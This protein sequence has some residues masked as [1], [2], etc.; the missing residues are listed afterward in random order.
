MNKFLFDDYQEAIEDFTKAIELKPDSAASAYLYRGLAKENLADS[1]GA[2]AD[3]AK[4]IEIEHLPKV[5]A[6]AYRYRGLVKEIHA[7]YQGALADYTRS[8]EL[9]PNVAKTYFLR[10]L[11]ANDFEDLGRGFELSAGDPDAYT[12]AVG[13]GPCFANALNSRGSAKD[14]IGNHQGAIADYTKA[15]ELVPGYAVPYR[16][17]GHSYL[18]LKQKDRA[19]ADFLRAIE[20]G[21]PV[22]QNILDMCK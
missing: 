22:P 12:K 21:L 3:L 17:R 13:L 5:I 14:Y 11:A 20:L 7:D 16:N 10:G 9:E 4:A 18:Y 6:Y 8:I 15:I 2:I 1:P 19:L